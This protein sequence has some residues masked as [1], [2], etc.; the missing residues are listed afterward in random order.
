MAALS[1]ALQFK[2]NSF[3]F[4]H[5]TEGLV[6]QEQ[7][8]KAGNSRATDLTV[9]SADANSLSISDKTAS[10]LIVFLLLLVPFFAISFCGSREAWAHGT[11]AMLIGLCLLIYPPRIK[12]PRMVAI[13][14]LLVLTLCLSAF[15]PASLFTMPEWREQ[16]QQDYGV[17][18]VSTRSAQPWVSFENWLFLL[19]GISWLCLCLSRG[20]S[21]AERRFTLQAMTLAIALFATLSIAFHYTKVEIPFWQSAWINTRYFGPFPNR[22]NFSGLLAV[23]AVLALATA[24]DAHRRKSYIWIFFALTLFPIF[25][26]VLLNTSRMGVL[27]FF[28]GVSMWMFIATIDRRSMQRLA[29]ST[30][31][32]LILASLFLL[33]GQHIISRFTQNVDLITTL[34]S[35]GRVRIFSDAY[36]VL[37]NYL[38]LGVGLGNF[39]PI[40]A[41][42]KTPVMGE[43]ITRSLHPENDWLWFAVE[44]GLP[45]LAMSL[46]AFFFI[47]KSFKS[48]HAERKQSSV[49]DHRLRNAGAVSVGLLTIQGLV[50]TPLHTIGL[51]TLAALMAGIALNPKRAVVTTGYSSAIL[52][53]VLGTVCILIGFLWLAVATGKPIIP[54]TAAAT[55][56]ANQSQALSLRGDNAAALDLMNKA[57]AIHPLQWNYYFDRAQ[58]KLRLGYP[59]Q[60]ALNDFAITRFL[61]P[62]HAGLCVREMEI[63]LSYSPPLAIPAVREAMRRDHNASFSYYQAIVSYLYA[64]PELRSAVRDLATDPKLK[65]FYLSSATGED[66]NEQLHYLL[67]NYPSLECFTTIEKLQLFKL[68]YAHGEKDKVVEKLESNIEWRKVGWPVL[69]EYH[70]K[71]G[72]FE[73]ACQIAMSYL[74]PPE[75]ITNR[76]SDLAELERSFLHNTSDFVRGLELYKIQKLKGLWDPALATLNQIAELPN[77]PDQVH[78][79]RSL[80]LYRKRDYA[81]SW[82]AMNLYLT[83]IESN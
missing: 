60:D 17:S 23:G 18:L 71:K 5:H 20:F 4:K 75:F 9:M 49:K 35:D 43:V 82:E 52:S 14:A 76:K 7:L 62:N 3:T 19:A 37:A 55:L 30:S 41:F 47:V 1:H 10:S 11:V 78:Y 80:I 67:V 12:L 2:K 32:L 27:L 68:W 40:F 74:H 16:I 34:S 24:L 59:F 77:L 21:S 38:T 79:E 54:G 83:K 36:T 13:T 22:N 51:T 26:A 73:K 58:L 72:D 65:L 56:Y 8:R 63:W 64:H 46:I 44:A 57:T 42:F 81:K 39:E 6:P 15:L 53:R 66:F 31:I 69:A 61:E 25:S 45:A 48:T 50:D 28:L 33:Y 70:A 29:I